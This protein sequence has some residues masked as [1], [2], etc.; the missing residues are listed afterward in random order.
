MKPFLIIQLRPNDAASDGE[1]DAFLRYGGLSPDDVV[2]VRMDQGHLPEVNLENY[3]AMIVGGGPWNVSDAPEKK[4]EAQTAGEAWLAQLI[5]RVVEADYPFMGACY[6]FGALTDNAV[7]GRVS[8]EQ[9][10]EQVAPVTISLTD[11]GKADPLFAD[12]KSDFRAVV[13]H[14]EACQELPEGAVLLATSEACPYQ[15]YRLGTNVYATQFHPEL[16]AEGI[17]IRIDVYRHAG[18]FPPEDGEKL[19][20]LFAQEDLT[21]VTKLLKNFVEQYKKEA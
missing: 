11:E 14:K 20:A 10:S 7:G 16:D 18:Y 3:S 4:D 19:K 17:A 2:R 13:G 21:E 8:K 15:M 12:L 1:F 9:Y 6:G 5:Q